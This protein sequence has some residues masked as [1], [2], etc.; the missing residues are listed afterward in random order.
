MM[1]NPLKIAILAGG[2]LGN[3]AEAFDFALRELAAGG[4]KRLVKSRNYATAPVDCA[5]GTPDFLNAAIIGEWDGSALELLQ[6]TQRI[7]R[8]AGRPADHGVNTS[9]PL[10][11]DLILFGDAIIDLPEL[12]VPHPRARERR[13]VLEPLAEL[14]PEWSFP[15]TGIRIKEALKALDIPKKR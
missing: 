14:V 1:A 8:R 6:L 15:D 13:F 2:N 12:K 9:R 4:V 10:D 3:V 5:P 11:L 7:E